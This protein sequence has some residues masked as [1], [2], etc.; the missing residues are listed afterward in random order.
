MSQTTPTRTEYDD[1]N[2]P[3]FGCDGSGEAS[4][5]YATIDSLGVHERVRRG[6]CYYCDGRGVIRGE[7]SYSDCDCSE[8]VDGWWAIPLYLDAPSQWFASR[9]AA[10]A[11]LGS[12]PKHDQSQYELRCRSAECV[13]TSDT[14]ACDSLARTESR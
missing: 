3:C 9:G 10:E 7:C 4:E 11:W 1:H 6:D 8:C 5:H 2:I 13:P 12:M 14:S